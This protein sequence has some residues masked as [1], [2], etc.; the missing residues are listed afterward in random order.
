ME[1]YH[2]QTFIGNEL[3]SSC[4][5]III[6]LRS[7]KLAMIEEVKTVEAYRN[8]GY[9]KRTLEKAIAQ[10]K[11]LGCDTVELCYNPTKN[12]GYGKRLYESCGF[13]EDG[14]IKARIILNEEN[15]RKT[16]KW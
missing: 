9:G 2:L 11:E 8:Q 10:A 1:Q 4:V 12:G 13:V 5:L 3:V 7:R 14:N 15:M 16:N 6:E